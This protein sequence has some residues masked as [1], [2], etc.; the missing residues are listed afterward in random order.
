MTRNETPKPGDLVAFNML[1]DATWFE[2]LS[3]DGFTLTVRE[4][5]T[6]YSPQQIDLSLIKQ[7]EAA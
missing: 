3:V 6:D 1:P 7:K 2:V 5:G 4:A